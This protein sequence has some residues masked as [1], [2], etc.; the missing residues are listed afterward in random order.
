M[1]MRTSPD[2]GSF[3]TGVGS[4]GF[5]FNG[6]WEV[7]CSGPSV[8]EEGFEG[9]STVLLEVPCAACCPT[10]LSCGTL[11]WGLVSNFFKLPSAEYVSSWK[12]GSHL[13]N[14]PPTE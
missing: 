2:D 11:P 5:P 7:F 10:E 12:P 8:G 4:N 6:D 1:V 14:I 9:I 3:V 13:L